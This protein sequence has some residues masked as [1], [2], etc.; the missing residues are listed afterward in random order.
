[1]G[2]KIVVGP[3]NKG[4][5]SD[6]LPFVIDNDSFPTLINAYQWRGRV[7]RKRGTKL[8][9]RLSRFI[10]TTDVA[11]NFSVTILPVPIATG[12]VSFV[13]G[14]EIFVDPGTT[15]NPLDQILITNSLGAVH[16]L[17]RI[18]GLLTITG[19]TPSTRVFYFPRLPVMGLEDLILEV[20]QFPGTLAFDT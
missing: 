7:K 1:M 3:I 2:E 17:N 9:N 19:S 8:L 18:T 5:R 4:I 20:N 16:T 15:A 11:G 13:I 6:R 14:N 10:G 12:I